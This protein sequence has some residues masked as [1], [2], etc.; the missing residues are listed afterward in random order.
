MQNDSILII[1]P[2]FNERENIGILLQKI[3]H[4]LPTADVLVV[5]DSSPDGTGQVVE[6]LSQSMCGIFLLTR[7]IKE[8]MGRA[9]I[10]G[11]KWA[12][13]RPY[14]IIFQMDADISHDPNDFPRF[15][16][17][18]ETRAL[19][20]GSRYITGGNVVNW[21]LSRFLLSYYSNQLVRWITHLPLCDSTGGYKC[22]RRELMDSL[23]L[24]EIS[25]SGYSFQIEINYLAWKHG[26]A[27]EEIPITF[28]DRKRGKSKMS[29][30]IIREAFF[31]LWKLRKRYCAISIEQ[32]GCRQLKSQM[33]FYSCSPAAEER[34]PLSRTK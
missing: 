8:G 31:L 3:K 4:V 32:Q 20:I 26:F 29:G 12:L 18:I 21:P 27:M 34:M 2:T 23:P 1:V 33:N 24:D 5:D 22:F 19:V 15:L 28:T 17:A 11:F 13:E 14:S 25:S 9:Y 7:A 16:K 10:S 6:E 30:N